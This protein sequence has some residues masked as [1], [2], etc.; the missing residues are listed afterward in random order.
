MTVLMSEDVILRRASFAVE[1][2][3]KTK[4]F[5]YLS[6][7]LLQYDPFS[8]AFFSGALKYTLQ[9]KKKQQEPFKRF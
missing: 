8:F 9:I 4:I 1:Q 6:H 5:Y 2:K 3:Q 7:L